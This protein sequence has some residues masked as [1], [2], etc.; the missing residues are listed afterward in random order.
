MRKKLTL[1]RDTLRQL[2]AELATAAGGFAPR[3]QTCFATCTDPLKAGAAYSGQPWTC[4]ITLGCVAI[5]MAVMAFGCVTTESSDG[6]AQRSGVLLNPRLAPLAFTLGVWDCA[7]EYEDAPPFTV[8][9]FN[10]ATAVFAPSVGGEWITA[11]FDE[12]ADPQNPLPAHTI[13]HL[14]IDPLNPGQD[15]SWNVL[16]SLI[17]DKSGQLEGR[18]VL[19]PGV[20]EFSGTY[21]IGLLPVPFHETVTQAPDRNSFVSV[22]S[23]DN[24][25]AGGARQVF[26]TERCVRR[27]AQRSVAESTTTQLSTSETSLC[28]MDEY[29]HWNCDGDGGGGDGGPGQGPQAN[30]PLNAG[31]NPTLWPASDGPHQM[32]SANSNAAVSQRAATPFIGAVETRAVRTPR[33]ATARFCDCYD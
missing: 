25:F 4:N 11:R 27:S 22:A 21:L 28:T 24:P 5:L 9:H 6:S 19:R 23:I 20:L 13:D 26:L 31:C 18:A 8:K 30:C 2:T 17:D 15:G 14:T 29:G 7:G 10:S 3:T 12:F 16:R 1:K 32:W 33:R